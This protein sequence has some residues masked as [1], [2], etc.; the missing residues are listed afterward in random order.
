MKYIL[1]LLIFP[2]I[3]YGQSGK[4]L[5]RSYGTLSNLLSSV[6]GR[7]GY[8][9]LIEG[10]EAAENADGFMLWFDP[11]SAAATSSTVYASF[12]VSTGRWFKI[13][14]PPGTGTNPMSFG[15]TFPTGF[16]VSNSPI[17]SS[18][19]ITVRGTTTNI[20]KGT[21]SGISNALATIDYVPPGLI[22]T[23]GL[24]IHSNML[25]GYSGAGSGVIQEIGIGPGLL[26]STG[27]LSGTF[28]VDV[29]YWTN[30]THT[31]TNPS[32][33]LIHYGY[34]V[35]GG[36]GGEAG[37]PVNVGLLG[38]LGTNSRSGRGGNAGGVT[39]GWLSGLPGT[40]AITVGSG[41]T[42]GIGTNTDCA[43]VIAQ[44]DGGSSFI[45][46]STGTNYLIAWGGGTHGDCTLGC[47]TGSGGGGTHGGW[48]GQAGVIDLG[49]VAKEGW[50]TN[51]ATGG[52]G[53]GG[54]NGQSGQRALPSAIKASQIVNGGPVD[55]VGTNGISGGIF[56]VGFGGS[57][58]GGASATAGK[59]GGSGGYPG[60]GGGGGGM[61]KI[62]TGTGMS[63]NGGSGANGFVGIISIGLR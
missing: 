3:C 56:C 34:L 53:A 10:V 21:G 49:I 32:G 47:S 44:T 24:T 30:G 17:I 12:A 7:D 8:M 27:T 35:G 54:I 14:V 36:E 61:G 6:P 41:G 11:A 43:G 38:T 60:G 51:N 5:L 57:G 15:L 37:C 23:S 52:G 16:T 19:Y 50:G 40:V 13:G 45:G 2:A 26:L 42:G 9:A 48:G 1:A 63:G 29:Q 46:A 55:T 58:G 22:T 33:S 39:E 18:G 59:A 25:G 20:I 62:G 4:T 28:F 31:W